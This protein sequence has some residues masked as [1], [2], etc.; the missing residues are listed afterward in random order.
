MKLG[1][2][3]DYTFDPLILVSQPVIK[4]VGVIVLLRLGPGMRLF[5]EPDALSDPLGIPRV[6]A[7]T[8]RI[9]LLY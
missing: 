4:R 6:V 5:V 3:T 7:E 1:L 8:V 9:E 2:R